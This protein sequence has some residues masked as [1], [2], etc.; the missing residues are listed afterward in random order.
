MAV[1]ETVI[2]AYRRL[3]TRAQLEAALA[4]A[5]ADRA[6]GVLVTQVSFQD[7]GGSGVPISGNP[8]ELIETLEVALQQLDETRAAGPPPLSTAVNFSLRRSET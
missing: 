2:A 4:K 3:Y 7:G 5:L 6:S 8:N 1:S